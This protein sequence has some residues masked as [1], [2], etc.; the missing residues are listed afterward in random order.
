M[1]EMEKNTETH[2][3]IRTIPT[4][5]PFL[6]EHSRDLQQAP[7]R[8]KAQYDNKSPKRQTRYGVREPS[9]MITNHKW[10]IKGHQMNIIPKNWPEPI[11]GHSRGQG[12]Y[13][14]NENKLNIQKIQRR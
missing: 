8:V 13:I 11:L 1:S 5:G 2:F 10:S 6:I 14:Q 4:G 12:I 3:H 7:L 9:G